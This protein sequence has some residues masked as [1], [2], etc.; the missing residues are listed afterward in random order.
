MTGKPGAYMSKKEDSMNISDICK[1]CEYSNDSSQE[2][3][4][5]CESGSLS[6]WSEAG[7]V[8]DRKIKRLQ[9]ALETIIDFS[10]MGVSTEHSVLETAKKALEDLDKP[11]LLQ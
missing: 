1:Y 10:K 8:K 3:C 9:I 4:G 5:S 11:E 2:Y 6:N 7:W